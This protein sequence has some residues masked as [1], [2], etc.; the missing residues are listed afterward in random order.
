MQDLWLNGN[1][2]RGI[3]PTEIARLA[4]LVTLHVDDNEIE[5]LVPKEIGSMQSLRKFQKASVSFLVGRQVR[6]HTLRI[7]FRSFLFV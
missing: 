4:D 3:I 6:T 5:G 2:I 1:H 7:T